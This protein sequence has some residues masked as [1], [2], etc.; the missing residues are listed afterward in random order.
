MVDTTQP[1][2]LPSQTAADEVAR[3]TSLLDQ[4]EGDLRLVERVGQ[5]LGGELDLER[6]YQTIYDQIGTALPVD[7]F[8]IVLAQPSARTGRFPLFVDNGVRYP[9]RDQALDPLIRWVM[10]HDQSLLFEDVHRESITIVDQQPAGY[11]PQARYARSWLGVPMTVRGEVKGVLSVQSFEPGLY[12]VREQ[13]LLGL[14]ASLAAVAIE[15]ARLFEQVQHTVEE[16]STPIVPV[17][18][19]VLI[20]PLIGRLDTH[21]A[22]QVME[23]LLVSIEEHAARVVI[24]DITGVT[25]VD[26]QVAHH[27]LQAARAAR[28]LG[29]ESVLTGIQP[30]VAE[31]IIAM[32][33]DLSELVTCSDLQSGIEYALAR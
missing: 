14:I 2:N 16:L 6:L 9:P 21:R 28:L 10:E 25:T 18:E 17:H 27:L 3:L 19:G 29:T 4:A 32:G 8:Y 23:A 20:L 22:E 11:A 13:R 30:E 26:T 7:S 12:G 5:A 24:I 33:L 1:L 31:S 15:N